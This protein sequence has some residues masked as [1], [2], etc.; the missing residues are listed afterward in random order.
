MDMDLVNG[1]ALL[2][3]ESFIFL[4]FYITLMGKTNFLKTEKAKCTLF[5]FFYTVLSCWTSAYLPFITHTVITLVAVMLIMSLITRTNV[6]NSAIIVFIAAAFIVI[7][8]TVTSAVFVGVLRTDMNSLLN[9][10][11]YYAIS[12][13]TSKFIQATLITLFSIRNKGRS[14]V[15]LFKSDSSQYMFAI[16]QLFLIALLIGSMVLNTGDVR[17]KTLY[18]VLLTALFILI[19]ALNFFDIREREQILM[20]LNRKKNLEEYVKNLEDVINVI[21]SEK[22]DFTNHIQTVYAICRL[23]KPNALESIES[24]LKRLSSDLTASYHFYETG[25]DYIDGLLAIKSHICFENDITLMVNIGAAFT[26]ADA[27]ESDIAGIVGNILNNAIECLKELPEAT[28]KQISFVTQIIEDRFILTI[29]NNGPEISENMAGHIFEKG[30][31]SKNDS[32]DHGFGL[33]IAHQLAE[34]NNG[35]IK[36]ESSIERTQ[37]IVAFNVK[38]DISETDIGFANVQGKGA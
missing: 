1:I 11:T 26:F 14:R 9:H 5:V 37:F 4:Y 29:G 12:A 21:R 28:D 3:V 22:H 36:V 33:Y 38:E 34:K 13:W 25:N 8:D 23:G 32:D 31:T 30:I 18:T 15:G 17:N 20:V 2:V 6:Y 27:D 10:P 7:I 16:L 35:S 24:Y 19:L